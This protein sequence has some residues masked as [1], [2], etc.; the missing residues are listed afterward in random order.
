MFKFI[1]GFIWFGLV[2]KNYFLPVINMT[3]RLRLAPNIS[4][5]K[6]KHVHAPLIFSIT[7][8]PSAFLQQNHQAKMSILHTRKLIS[9]LALPRFLLTHILSFQKSGS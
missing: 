7:D 9:Q 3:V 6:Y 4:L 8:I 5:F 1:K 2:L